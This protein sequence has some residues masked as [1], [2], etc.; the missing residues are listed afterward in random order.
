VTAKTVYCAGE[1]LGGYEFVKPADHNGIT[2]RP[3]CYLTLYF[4]DH[5][6]VSPN[7]IFT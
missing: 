6:F 1:Q 2:A 5:N 7:N 4:F 3:G